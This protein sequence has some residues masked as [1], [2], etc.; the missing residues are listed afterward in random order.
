MLFV[1][2]TEEEAEV[3]FELES[4]E[5]EAEDEGTDATSPKRAELPEELF[6][7]FEAAEVDWMN[8][9]EEGR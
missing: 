2:E 3:Q 4:D 8:E 6:G 7:A 9:G 5:K 1:V